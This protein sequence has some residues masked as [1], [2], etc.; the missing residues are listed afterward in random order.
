MIEQALIQ[1]RADKALKDEVAKIY[2]AIGLDLP[3]AC[4]MFL[5]RSRQERGLPFPATLDEKE[6]ASQRAL[7]A[8]AELRESA[9]KL[10]EMSL[11]EINAEIKAAR[12]ER[13]RKQ[14]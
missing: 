7:A 13:K 6:S 5:I 1:F 8:F 10:P 2:E 3:T 4:R 11:E 14:S 9:A 12:D